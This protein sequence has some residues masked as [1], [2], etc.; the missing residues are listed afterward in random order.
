MAIINP[1]NEVYFNTAGT[2]WLDYNWQAGK[3]YKIFLSD[4]RGRRELVVGHLPI[5]EDVPAPASGISG[6]RTACGWDIGIAAQIFPNG[7]KRFRPIWGDGSVDDR[8][9][10]ILERDIVPDGTVFDLAP[11]DDTLDFST[12]FSGVARS[13]T[14]T[15]FEQDH[16]YILWMYAPQSSAETYFATCTFMNLSAMYKYSNRFSDRML[17]YWYHHDWVRIGGSGNTGPFDIR[18]GTS[19]HQVRK[20]FKRRIETDETKG[21]YNS[22]KTVIDHGYIDERY[23]RRLDRNEE[24]FFGIIDDRGGNELTFAQLMMDDRLNTIINSD[25]WFINRPGED[26]VLK[27][28]PFT[29]RI[30]FSGSSAYGLYQRV[31]ME[32]YVAD[33]PPP[34]PEPDPDPPPPTIDCKDICVFLGD[35]YVTEANIEVNFID[36][37]DWQLR[38]YEYDWST[39]SPELNVVDT[40]ANGRIAVVRLTHTMTETDDKAL[41]PYDISVTVRDL[42]YAL[43]GVEDTDAAVLTFEMPCLATNNETG[44]SV[45]DISVPE[46]GAGDT[47]TTAIFTITSDAPIEGQDRTVDYE[48]VGITASSSQTITVLASDSNDLPFLMV[49]ETPSTRLYLDG[50]FTRFWNQETNNG[51]AAS[52]MV[53]LAINAVEWLNNGGPQ[54]VLII[55][56]PDTGGTFY[57]IN[58]TGGTGFSN[59]LDGIETGL[60]AGWTITRAYADTLEN[61]SEAYF[62][63]F[64]VIIYIASGRN[65]VP[66]QP[67]DFLLPDNHGMVQHIPTAVANGVGLAMLSD[68]DIFQVNANNILGR[69]D[70]SLLFTG[71]AGVDRSLETITVEGSI[72]KH[73]NH[74]LF[75]GLTGQ[76]PVASSEAY[77]DATPDNPDFVSTSGQVVFSDGETSKQ[78]SVT[79]NC[80]DLPEEDETF[81]LVISNPTIGTI[82]KAEGIA[83]I[84]DS[85]PDV[86]E[87]RLAQAGESYEVYIYRDISGSMQGTEM[88]LNGNTN[89]QRDQIAVQILN[90]FL[91]PSA[92][93][94]GAAGASVTF[95]TSYVRWV[96]DNL[97][98]NQDRVSI[99]FITDAEDGYG[100]GA[101]NLIT[102][103]SASNNHPAIETHGTVVGGQTAASPAATAVVA[104]DGSTWNT[105]IG[106]LPA[107]IVDMKITVVRLLPQSR[108]DAANQSRIDGTPNNTAIAEDG[109]NG[110]LTTAPA[111][112]TQASFETFSSYTTGEDS[113]LNDRI[114]EAVL[115]TWDANC[116]K[117]PET[118]IQVQA[119]DEQEAINK[120]K[121]L[122]NCP[123]D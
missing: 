93:V 32:E 74:P 114:S 4:N 66:A 20:L 113:V 46:C 87:V 39:P 106:A 105:T 25:S 3:E 109:F 35:D 43:A 51:D 78:V 13:G 83:T 96:L 107:H 84:V 115:S 31:K 6:I 72:T 116:T 33:V 23:T 36:P 70:S 82:A 73:G 7:S 17:L 119:A 50:S 80:D 118:V 56:D 122:L 47:N 54:N 85:T 9:Y 52:I 11:G 71:G 10:R 94:V 60:G 49:R 99:L 67:D 58:G 22:I 48:T 16:E 8:I 121:P 37:P 44:F 117:S 5:I 42:D 30:D 14:F 21:F 95:F 88:T 111:T 27:Y 79:V 120:A 1:W 76:F 63:A 89:A 34:D 41:L 81:K 68:H 108:I 91:I 100:S 103:S 123:D 92:N 29:N 75:D 40:E 28:S 15:N 45:N 61:N 90:D 26:T 69:I 112:V 77:I 98:T 104:A 59:T 62:S 53:Q 57:D 18:H 19:A 24:Y 65:R 55:G 86:T 12:I 38:R 102:Y 101:P 97:P 64:S 2:L 110:I